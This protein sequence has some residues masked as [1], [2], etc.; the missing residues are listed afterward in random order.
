MTDDTTIRC[1]IDET[2]YAGPVISINRP[3]DPATVFRAVQQT[4]PVGYYPV[5]VENPQPAPVYEH[6]G[7]VRAEMGLRVRSALAKAGRSRGL[8]TPVDEELYSV[9][10][11]LA[12]LSPDAAE[13]T[14]YRRELAATEADVALLHEQVAQARGRLKTR[15]ENDRPTGRAEQTLFELIRK[16]S[17]RATAGAAARQNL[18]EA[19]ER[20]REQRTRR[21]Q[22]VRLEDRAGNLRRRAHRHL[23]DRLRSEYVTAIAELTDA[24]PFDAPPPVAALAVARVASLSAPVVLAYD[25]F[26]TADAAYRWLG[27]P[28]IR[29]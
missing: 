17:E 15:R 29:I 20:A 28:L 2:S 18:T 21:D 23:V 19:R 26:S 24:A 5:R 4:E 25:Q 16:L 14:Q 22:R 9:R 11:R 7:C 12:S 10:E 3:V 13:M 1:R 6:I 27:A 8:T